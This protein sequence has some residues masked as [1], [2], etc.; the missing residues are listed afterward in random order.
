MPT[1]AVISHFLCSQDW[2][3]LN[4]DAMSLDYR[5]AVFSGPNVRMVLFGSDD[6]DTIVFKGAKDE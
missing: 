3:P 5:S 6:E 2:P 4:Y 1:A